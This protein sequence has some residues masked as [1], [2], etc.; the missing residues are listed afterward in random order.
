MRHHHLIVTGIPASG[1]STIARAL[2]EAL[3]LEMFDK[4][5][6]L[7]DLFNEKGIGDKHWRTTL[8]RAADEVLRQRARQSENSIIVSWW[9][10]PASIVASGTPTEWLSELQGVL[11]EIYCICDPAIAVQRFQSRIRHSGHLDQ[12][13]SHA[14]LLPQFQQHAALG[15][16]GIGRLVEVNTEGV[17][18]I[19]DVIA[20]INSSLN[21]DTR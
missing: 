4:D 12:L 5:E 19:A 10:H 2:S 15:P 7:E 14:D 18:K 20:R 16:L 3:G 11:I 8:S 6:I 13:K 1:K 17:T 9:R 21:T